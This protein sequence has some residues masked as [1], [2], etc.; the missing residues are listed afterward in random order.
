MVLVA[1]TFFLTVY[2]KH[3]GVLLCSAVPMDCY[4]N[5][6]LF[7]TGVLEMKLYLVI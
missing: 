3:K 6:L 2:P 5:V 4:V 7:L 1:W